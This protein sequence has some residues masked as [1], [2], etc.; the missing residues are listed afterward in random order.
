MVF[1]RYNTYI[2]FLTPNTKQTISSK[3]FFYLANTHYVYIS[4]IIG[5]THTHKYIN[6]G[7]NDVSMGKTKKEM[8]GTLIDIFVSPE[9]LSAVGSAT[10]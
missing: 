2:L 9:R 7:G 1:E 6:P 3:L 4:H 5:K 8:R 10:V